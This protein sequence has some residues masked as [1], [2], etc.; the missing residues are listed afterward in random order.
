MEKKLLRRTRKTAPQKEL[1][2]SARLSNL[3]GAFTAD[4]RAMPKNARIILADDIYTT[5]STVQ[6][7]AAA[8]KKAG[9]GEVFSA[10]LAGGKDL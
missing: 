5:G 6:A 7:C 2:A 3:T 4:E 9:A 10:V 1:G 8:L